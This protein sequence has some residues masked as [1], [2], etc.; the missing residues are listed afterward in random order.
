MASFLSI[1]FKMRNLNFS[2]FRVFKKQQS[3][4][5]SLQTFQTNHSFLLSKQLKSHISSKYFSS[6]S[7]KNLEKIKDKEKNVS[8]KEQVSDEWQQSKD[9]E[10]SFYYE[11]LKT[12]E[13]TR[14]QPKYFL[15]YDSKENPIITMLRSD[16]FSDN[17]YKPVGYWTKIYWIVFLSFATAAILKEFIIPYFKDEKEPEKPKRED[18]ISMRKRLES[19][20]KE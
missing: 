9:S 15:P 1:R 5:P 4:V 8:D 11:N 10:G 12:G 6:E 3:F 13:R 2:T 18:Y 16:K 7:E 17:P 14:T 19:K 20:S